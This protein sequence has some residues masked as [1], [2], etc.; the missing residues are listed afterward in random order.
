[1]EKILTL[2]GEC[3][4]CKKPMCKTGCPIA[5]NIPEFIQEIKNNNMQKAYQIL[6]DNNILSEICS[7]ICPT[8]NQCMRKM[9][10]RNKRRSS[11]NKRFRK[12]CK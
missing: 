2:A 10:K 11:S 9:Y 6:Q 3:L 1:M 8:E 5:T 12:I 7:R 4:N